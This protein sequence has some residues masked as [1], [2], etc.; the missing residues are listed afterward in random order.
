VH[1]ARRLAKGGLEG[2]SDP[3]RRGHAIVI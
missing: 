1:T 2:A 3:R